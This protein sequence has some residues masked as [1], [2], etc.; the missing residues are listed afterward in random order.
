MRKHRKLLL[1]AAIVMSVVLSVGSTMAYLTST[2]SDVNVMTLGNVEIA[3]HEYERVVNANGEYELVTSPRG[4]GYKLQ[5][6]SQAKP[7]FPAVGKVTGWD[8]TVIWFDQL[9]DKAVGGQMVLDGL[10]NVQDK[11]IASLETK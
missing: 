1:V 4:E 7:L 10:K 6:F 3:Q 8:D 11:I 9:S 2:V 5:E